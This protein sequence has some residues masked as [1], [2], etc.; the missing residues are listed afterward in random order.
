MQTK[1]T[2][3]G[4]ERK[5]KEF[6][7]RVSRQMR[8]MGYARN[9]I[10][11]YLG[12]L[13]TIQGHF[14]KPIRAITV[15]ELKGFLDLEL[16]KGRSGSTINAHIATFELVM[17]GVFQK[18]VRVGFRFKKPRQAL[19]VVFS[20]SEAVRIIE[21]EENPKYR[22]MFQLMYGSGLRV[23]E[24]TK[25]RVGDV[26]FERGMIKVVQGK[27]KKDRL[28]VLSPK[29]KSGLLGLC[30]G[31]TA[32]DWL[33]PSNRQGKLHERSVQMK[34][35]KALDKAGIQKA[36]TCHSLRHSFATHLLENGTDIRYIQELL[37]HAS[38]KT[39]Q[40]YTK[41]AATSLVRIESPL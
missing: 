12:C 10:S 14:K 27:G 11:N 19:P 41:V 22:L 21:A 40:V 31:R 38:I 32:N 29:I 20:H 13:R 23:G 3:Q 6:E 25:I 2:N 37:G 24:V 15:D 16:K 39:T 28:S 8:V 26:D 4:L 1:S 18:P 30:E 7:T 35:A 17:K 5:K 33:F 34:F 9:T 36:G